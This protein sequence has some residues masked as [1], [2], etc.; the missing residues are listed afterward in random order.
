MKLRSIRSEFETMNSA[1]TTVRSAREQIADQLRNEILADLFS[2]DEP[3]R[4][5]ALA[6]RFGVSRGPIRDVLLQLSQEGALVYK[7]NSGVRV[8]T[9]AANDERDFL[10]SLRLKIE[11][12]ALRVFVRSSGEEDGEELRAIL[13]RM[14]GACRDKDVP[15]IVGSD[16]ALHRHLI[17]RGASEK[18]EAV[19][20]SITVRI[21]MDYS[22]LTRHM[23]IFREHEQLVDAILSG[24]LKQARAALKANL[25]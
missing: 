16:L 2:D 12:E 20:Q 1:A 7:P 11:L 4:E 13:Q 21:R 15:A 10:M 5:A 23:D 9:P 18:V 17:R 6:E 24:D 25:I 14:K 22:R 19:W 8:N 3:M